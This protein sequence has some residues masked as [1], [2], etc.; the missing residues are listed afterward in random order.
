MGIAERKE[1]D[2]ESMRQLILDAAMELYHEKGIEALTIRAVAERIEFSPATIYLYF[3][4][5]DEIV[6]HLYNI[7]FGKFYE[8]Q[9]EWNRAIA[10]PLERLRK[11]CEDYIHWGVENPK[12]YDLMFILEIP[13]SVIEQ[14]HCEDNGKTSFSELKNLMSECIAANKLKIKDPEFA[15]LMCWNMI[16][17]ITS[18]LIKKRIVIPHEAVPQMVTSMLDTYF[19]FITK[20]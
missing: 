20:Q 8:R 19:L 1:R 15:A 18:L 13:M 9:M 10:D 12:L 17:G 3:R 7:A 5:K 11:G 4:D 14:E 16:H 2:R 6:Y